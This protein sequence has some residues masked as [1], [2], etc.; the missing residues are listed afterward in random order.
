MPSRPH[1][2]ARALR[3]GDLMQR[4]VVTLSPDMPIAAIMARLAEQEVSGAPVVDERDRL[5]GVVSQTD[6]LRY[7]RRHDRAPR[8]REVSAF[9]QQANGDVFV[10]H[11][12]VDADDT[13]CARDIMTPAAFTTDVSTPVA[14]VARFMVQRHVH[15]ILVTRRGRLAGMVTSM[16][17]LRALLP[18]GA[19]ARR[20]VARRH[21][22]RAERR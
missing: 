22:P 4:R 6:L 16:D 20:G 1:G 15:R 10:R 17:L 21:R 11:L 12:Q 19:R 18:R 5:V 13:T 14:E 9:Y 7:E 8:P 2:P 3:A